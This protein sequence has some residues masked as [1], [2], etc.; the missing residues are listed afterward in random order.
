MGIVH[1]SSGIPFLSLPGYD[2]LCGKELLS[3]TITVQDVTIYEVWEVV[4]IF[5]GELVEFC[6]REEIQGDLYLINLRRGQEK[7]LPS[8]KL[9]N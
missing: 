5:N 6:L 4:K 9:L 3:L 2:Y 1:G 7:L 8:Q